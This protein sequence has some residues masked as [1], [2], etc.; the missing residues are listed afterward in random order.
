M[1]YIK[2]KNKIFKLKEELTKEQ[3]KKELNLIEI[4]L[5]RIGKNIKASRAFIKEQTEKRLTLLEQ[6]AILCD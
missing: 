6:K 1:K 5:K 2:D 3:I 4:E